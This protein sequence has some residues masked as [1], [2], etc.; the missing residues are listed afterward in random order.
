MLKVFQQMPIE[1]KV[2]MDHSDSRKVGK[3]VFQAEEQHVQRP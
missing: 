3:K 1:T 2:L